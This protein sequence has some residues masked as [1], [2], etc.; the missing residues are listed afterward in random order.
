MLAEQVD[1]KDRLAVIRTALTSILERVG[2]CPQ[3]QAAE[4]FTS[5]QD[6]LEAKSAL[7]VCA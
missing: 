7:Q 6:V 4:P 1:L 5:R 2:S 3:L